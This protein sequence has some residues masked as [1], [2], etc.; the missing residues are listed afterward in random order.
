MRVAVQFVFSVACLLST[1][2]LAQSSIS[3]VGRVVNSGRAPLDGV[4]VTLAISS[5]RNELDRIVS[6]RSN[7]N[8]L[9][10]LAKANVGNFSELYLWIEEPYTFAPTRV[11]AMKTDMWRKKIDDIVLQRTTVGAIPL[12]EAAERVAA[13]YEIEDLKIKLG[14]QDA[15]VG[16]NSAATLAQRVLAK[17]DEI[18]QQGKLKAVIDETAKLVDRENQLFSQSQSTLISLAENPEF[19]LLANA[20]QLKNQEVDAA[21]KDYLQGKRKY[22]EWLPAYVNGVS[23]TTIKAEWFIGKDASKHVWPSLRPRSGNNNFENAF[24]IGSLKPSHDA[25][26]DIRWPTALHVDVNEPPSADEVNRWFK[27]H[28]GNSKTL[29]KAIML[30]D[31]NLSDTNK[32]EVEVGIKAA[33]PIVIPRS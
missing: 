27:A 2:V 20:E 5:E 29:F 31:P 11:A 17:C 8:G 14:L 22:E 25:G 16:K 9:F 24:T 15:A 23:P 32:K 6:D 4:S 26:S 33:D 13:L 12:K 3:V 28:S 30:A 1:P 10:Q 18:Q 21:L 7:T 19:A